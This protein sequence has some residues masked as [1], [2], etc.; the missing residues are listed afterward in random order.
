LWKPSIAAAAGLLA[1]DPSRKD[2]IANRRYGDPEN[3][4]D[5][6]GAVDSNQCRA[7]AA[8]ASCPHRSAPSGNP[9]LEDNVAGSERQG[10]E[11]QTRQEARMPM[12]AD[13]FAASL[14]GDF[15]RMCDG[16]MRSFFLSPF[17]RR[18]F[19]LPSSGDGDVAGGVGFSVPRAE[20]SETDKSYELSCELPGLTEKDIDLTLRDGVI[21]IKGRKETRRDE[22]DAKKNF[23][24][25]ER[26]YG[27]FQRSFRMPE[28]VDEK[29][30]AALFEN[31]VL[32]VTLP[33]APG[34][35]GQQTKIPIAKR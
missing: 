25:S 24:F 14:F 2:A 16:M 13:P 19:E 22:K 34:A 11:Q 21:E 32:T 20:F 10:K 12:R 26:S 7:V 15:D 5:A 1:P 6:V 23:H 18:L 30:I 27:S 35:I 29:A 33:K 28:N 3:V 9:I 31:G 4:G 8:I 17:E